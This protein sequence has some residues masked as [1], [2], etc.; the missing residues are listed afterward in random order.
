ML[1]RNYEECV[2]IDHTDGSETVVPIERA[3]NMF[4]ECY[5]DRLLLLPDFL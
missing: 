4:D 3:Y 5:E 1:A 2:R